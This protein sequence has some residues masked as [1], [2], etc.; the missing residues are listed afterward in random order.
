MQHLSGVIVKLVHTLL[1]ADPPHCNK[2]ISETGDGTIRQLLSCLNSF[3]H[4]RSEAHRG[5]QDQSIKQPIALVQLCSKSGCKW[6]LKRAQYAKRGLCWY[7]E[8]KE[9]NL[10]L[11]GWGM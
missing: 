5:R 7:L 6:W 2:D 10:G 11:L 1:V 4:C 3:C 8:K 9:H